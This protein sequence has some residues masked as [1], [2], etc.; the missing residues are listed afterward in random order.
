MK[1]TIPEIQERIAEVLPEGKVVARHTD[2][3]HFYEVDMQIMEAIT[4]VLPNPIYP[5]VTGKLQILKDESLINYK[6][7]QVIQ[8]FFRTFDKITKENLMEHL[9]L[10]ERVPEDVLSDASDIGTQIHDTRE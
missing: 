4:T 3:G 5:S 2:Q 8:Y 9:A 10:A 7:N 1:L 6:K